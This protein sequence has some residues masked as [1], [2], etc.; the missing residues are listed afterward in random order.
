MYLGIAMDIACNF[1][2]FTR[3]SRQETPWYSSRSG[4]LGG[5][6]NPHDIFINLDVAIKIAGPSKKQKQSH[7]E[8]GSPKKGVEKIQQEHQQQVTQLKQ[9][10]TKPMLINKAKSSVPLNKY[11]PRKVFHSNYLLWKKYSPVIIYWQIMAP[12]STIFRTN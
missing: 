9:A 11:S 7:Q 12:G 8:N 3:T 1:E 2:S 10:I 4:I 6:K 5:R